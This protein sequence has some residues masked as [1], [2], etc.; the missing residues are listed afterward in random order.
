MIKWVEGWKK[1][2]SALIRILMAISMIVTMGLYTFN[3]VLVNKGR[4]FL[5][6]TRQEITQ[7]IDFEE[8]TTNKVMYFL[9]RNATEGATDVSSGSNWYIVPDID[10]TCGDANY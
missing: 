1:F 5:A 3:I 2:F 8:I 9:Y 6:R 4:F 10:E 7:T